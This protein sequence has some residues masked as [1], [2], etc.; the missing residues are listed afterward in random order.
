MPHMGCAIATTSR[1]SDRGT[2]GDARPMKLPSVP[3]VWELMQDN[4]RDEHLGIVAGCEP[5]RWFSVDGVFG[6]ERADAAAAEF[7]PPDDSG[8]HTFSGELE[9]GKQEGRADI[10]G[11][12]VADLHASLSTFSF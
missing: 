6:K 8:W 2:Q 9:E 3:I 11:D 4:E 10:A 1:R 5:F 12:A 7:P